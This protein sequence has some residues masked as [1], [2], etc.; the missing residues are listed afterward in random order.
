VRTAP[1]IKRYLLVDG[2]RIA[3]HER[4]EG[5]AIGFLH[6]NPTSS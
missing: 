3:F 1:L 5:D 4:G 2:K 6:G